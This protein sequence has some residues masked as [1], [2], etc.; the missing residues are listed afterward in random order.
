MS[1]YTGAFLVGAHWFGVPFQNFK[2]FLEYFGFYLLN[3]IYSNDDTRNF[4]LFVYF[5]SHNGKIKFSFLQTVQS[6]RNTSGAYF[7]NILV[8]YR[9]IDNSSDYIYCAVSVRIL[10]HIMNHKGIGPL[11][12]RHKVTTTYLIIFE[13]CHYLFQ[14]RTESI[15]NA[16]LTI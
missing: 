16:K 12:N 4:C 13:I 5:Q 10:K 15:E 9:K 2:H 8:S 1:Y 14:C 3:T 7:F 6:R 11:W